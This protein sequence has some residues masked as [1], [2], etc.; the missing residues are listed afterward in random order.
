[1]EEE[2]LL[3]RGIQ[4]MQNAI[5][6]ANSA[7]QCTSRAWLEAAGSGFQS[8]TRAVSIAFRALTY[9]TASRPRH[10]QVRYRIDSNNRCVG[11]PQ[12]N[13]RL[14][15]SAND[16]SRMRHNETQERGNERLRGEIREL[17]GPLES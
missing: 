3:T 5:R 12:V 17:K 14:Q 10:A 6:Y 4:G 15:L 8:F 13:R 11:S 9:T 2:K 1:M 16:E 7:F